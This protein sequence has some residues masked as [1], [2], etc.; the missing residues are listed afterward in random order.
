MVYNLF[1]MNTPQ[2]TPTR[3]TR[4]A[5]FGTGST[6]IIPARSLSVSTPAKASKPTVKR[7][8][9]DEKGARLWA[10]GT[11]FNFGDMGGN[12]FSVPS[13]SRP[14]DI[15]IL[16]VGVSGAATCDCKAGERGVR[17]WH[18]A[19]W[20]IANAPVPAALRLMNEISDVVAADEPFRNER[21]TSMV[22]RG[23]G[24]GN[25]FIRSYYNG[26]YITDY[27][28]KG[29]GNVS[30]FGGWVRQES[31][32]DE[33]LITR[34]EEISDMQMDNGDMTGAE[35]AAEIAAER[36]GVKH[37]SQVCYVCHG[38]KVL[39][40][41]ECPCCRGVG[42]WLVPVEEAASEPVPVD[43]ESMAQAVAMADRFCTKGPKVTPKAVMA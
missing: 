11:A 12:Q 8:S 1:I 14:G 42:R 36:V 30:A 10:D 22:C 24:K 15:H 7:E 18:V 34:I 43:A 19:A 17:C 41:R 32:A 4:N 2:P 35:Q 38:A 9:V 5:D 31:P 25:V 40:G 20:E 29:C 6:A 26:S 21:E 23:C 37:C 33:T 16:T 39:G 13:D 28:C 27:A 3:D